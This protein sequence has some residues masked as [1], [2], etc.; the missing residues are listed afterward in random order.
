MALVRLT[1]IDATAT[2]SF[3]APPHVMKMT[4]AACAH[5]PADVPTLLDQL[6]AYDPGFAARLQAAIKGA[7][8]EDLGLVMLSPGEDR[9]PSLQ[10]SDGGVVIFNLLA[11]RIVQISNRVG[12]IEREDRGRMRRNGRPVQVFYTYTLPAEWSIVP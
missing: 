9:E 5:N 8:D 3:V 12:A 11:K 10:A 1:I 6:G 2:V 4:T 7:K